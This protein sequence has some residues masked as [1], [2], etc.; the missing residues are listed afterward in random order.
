V[1]SR[2]IVTHSAEETIER[3]REIGARLKPPVLVLL[4]GELG[5]GKTTL[6]KGIASGLG[7]ANEDEVTSPTFTL[8]HKYARGAPV[9]HVDLYRI[10]DFH[11]FETL[12]LEDVFAEKAVVIVE[13]PDKF[14]L[15][16][17]WPVMRI[18]LEH[19]AEDTRRISIAEPTVVLE[20]NST[21]P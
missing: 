9:Y 14:T 13:W 15:R 17:Q 3:G 12:G 2:E 16:T 20:A 19:V 11:D 1:A 4:S 8:V 6:T 18:R 21:A 5:A 10:G 7:A